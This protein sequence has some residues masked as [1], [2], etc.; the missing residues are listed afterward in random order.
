[1]CPL[2]PYRL[3]KDEKDSPEK[4]PDESSGT[5]SASTTYS[6]WVENEYLQENASE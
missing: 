2:F 6:W 1:M 4:T 5:K 3:I